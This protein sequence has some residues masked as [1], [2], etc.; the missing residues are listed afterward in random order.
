LDA[1]S[2][3][4]VPKEEKVSVREMERLRLKVKKIGGKDDV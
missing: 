1:E 2:D 4:F 3:E